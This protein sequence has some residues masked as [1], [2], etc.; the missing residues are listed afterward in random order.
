LTNVPTDDPTEPTEPG[1]P[2]PPN[3]AH[4]VYTGAPGPAVAGSTPPQPPRRGG[5][6]RWAWVL[7]GG[8]ALVMIAIVVV[9]VIV[10]NTVLGAVSST[11][12][13]DQP[14]A[15]PTSDPA[16][17][18]LPT[19]AAT[20]EPSVTPTDTA[21]S[22]TVTSLDVQADFGTPF[23]SFPIV[24][25]WE[26]SVFDQEGVNQAENAELGC[27]FTT[28]QNRQAAIDS[29][30]TGDRSDTEDTIQTLTQL[31]LDSVDEA[32]VV[33]ELG[34]ID[35][36]VGMADSA[37]GLEFAT[38]R[39]EYVNPQ[40]GGRYVNDIAMRAMP[41]PEAYLYLVVSCPAAVIDSGDSP[42]ED[43]LGQ[44]AVVFE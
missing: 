15:A 22:D 32:E 41:L 40:D 28:S 26:V 8:A 16:E 31:M 14:F 36:A 44:S 4:A 30:A 42:F 43:L 11:A 2:L 12:E 39:V 21:G 5:L 23:W 24:D 27:L 33:G 38:S 7:I 25:G 10:V 3:S 29:A 35:V 18:T 6:P 19:E 1:V 13:G 37:E 34:S 9:I 20:T 17:T